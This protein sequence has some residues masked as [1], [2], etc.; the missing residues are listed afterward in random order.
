[1][2]GVFEAAGRYTKV[3]EGCTYSYSTNQRRNDILL[4]AAAALLNS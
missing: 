4:I 1:M 2:E 3:V